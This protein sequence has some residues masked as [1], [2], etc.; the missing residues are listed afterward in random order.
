[1]RIPVSA[2]YTLQVIETGHTGGRPVLFAHP[3]GLDAHVWD[4]VLPLL[5]RDLRLLAMDMRGHG[6]SDVPVPPYAMGALIRDA[7][8]VCDAL[9]LRDCVIV[10]NSIGGM[11]AQGLAAKRLDL[12]RGLVLANTAP[13]IGTRAL[14]A[15][16]IAHVEDLGM[17]GIAEA[18]LTRWFSKAFLRDGPVDLWRDRLLRCDARGY[19]GCAA[20]I[21][22]TDLYS[23]TGALRLP[24]LVTA[25]TEDGSTPPDLVRELADLIPGAEFRLLRG[26]GHVPAVDQ[27]EAFA[28]VLTDFLKRI[29]HV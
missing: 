20:A 18:T 25:G 10:G 22:G 11:I 15:D 1:M 5:P 19:V 28:S 17:P 7:E 3:L 27:P 21:A 26:S 14:W 6:G 29:G 2:D 8:A 4:S 12:V 13:K 16:R 9:E 23:T 24:T